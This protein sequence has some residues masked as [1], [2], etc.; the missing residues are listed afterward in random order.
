VP[1]KGPRGPWKAQDGSVAFSGISLRQKALKAAGERRRRFWGHSGGQVLT[2]VTHYA[3]IDIKCTSPQANV[4]TPVSLIRHHPVANPDS[5][6]SDAEISR[7]FKRVW[8]DR[9]NHRD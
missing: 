1:Q 2:P 4:R 7:F 5:D 9:P 3:S 8:P 6:H